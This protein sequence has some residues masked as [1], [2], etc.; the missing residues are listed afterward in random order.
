MLIC[1]RDVPAQERNEC[2]KNSIKS[3]LP[4]MKDGYASLGIY[5]FDPY[6]IKKSIIE[7]NTGTI[8]S[9]SVMKDALISGFSRAQVKNVRTKVN[10]R[11]MYIELDIK[12]PFLTTEALYTG[13]GGFNELRINS[14][15]YMKVTLSKNI[16]DL[17][18]R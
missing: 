2:I 10:Q 12:L 11:K 14:S 3:L 13:F 18:K 4:T 6:K 9:K 8:F 7:F 5:H 1:N 15:G 17:C 16:L